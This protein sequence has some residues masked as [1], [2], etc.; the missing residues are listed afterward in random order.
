MYLLKPFLLKLFI[1]FALAGFAFQPPLV[2][3]DDD[4]KQ[5]ETGEAESN[6]SDDDDEEP[7]CE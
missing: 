7:D 2:S 4:I 6:Q 1:L 5:E 3:A